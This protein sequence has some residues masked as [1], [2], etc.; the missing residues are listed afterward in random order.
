MW[1]E[2]IS[3][4]CESRFTNFRESLHLVPPIDDCQLLSAVVVALMTPRATRFRAVPWKEK[5]R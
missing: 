1:D 4:V 2:W 5:G 3:Q